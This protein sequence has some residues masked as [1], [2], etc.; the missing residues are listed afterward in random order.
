MN[1]ITAKKSVINLKCKHVISKKIL[2][3]CFS[4]NLGNLFPYV[5]CIIPDA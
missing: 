3:L 4:E 1:V 5:P 2:S